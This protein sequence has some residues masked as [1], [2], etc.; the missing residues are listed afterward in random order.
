MDVSV[1]Y[2]GRLLHEVAV[3][4]TSCMF[5]YG[6]S[7]DF[8]YIPED[9]QIIQFPNVEVLLD[10]KQAKYTLILLQNAGLVLYQRNDKIYAKRLGKCKV[11]CAFSKQLEKMAEH[12]Q[13]PGSLP[14][15]EEREIFD[16]S[17]FAQGDSLARRYLLHG[18]QIIWLVGLCV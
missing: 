8:G 2:R 12:T 9:M 11:F 17:Q 6:N 16:Y 5:T 4:L 3:K 14:R 15:D 18:L 7:Q 10:Q 1:Y 13:S